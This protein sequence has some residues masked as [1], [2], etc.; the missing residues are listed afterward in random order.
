MML[1]R[2]SEFQ[3]TLLA[4]LVWLATWLLVRFTH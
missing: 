2:L 3:L 4:G 1:A